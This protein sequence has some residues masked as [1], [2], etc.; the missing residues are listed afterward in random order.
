M[1]AIGLAILGIFILL[2]GAYI[3]IYPEKTKKMMMKISKNKTLFSSH[4]SLKN[5]SIVRLPFGVACIN[6]KQF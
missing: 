1:T 5:Y 4:N 2:K 6:G 3:L